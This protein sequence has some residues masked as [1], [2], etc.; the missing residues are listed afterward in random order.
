[1]PAI[2]PNN[3]VHAS[4]SI[5]ILKQIPVTSKGNEGWKIVKKLVGLKDTGSSMFCRPIVLWGRPKSGGADAVLYDRKGIDYRHHRFPLFSRRNRIRSNGRQSFLHS[6]SSH[7]LISYTLCTVLSV[8]IRKVRW[9]RIQQIDRARSPRRRSRQAT[10]ANSRF[11]LHREDF[12]RASYPLPTFRVRLSISVSLKV[13]VL[14]LWYS[15]SDYNQLH[16]DPAIGKAIG[17]GGV[18]SHGLIAYGFAAR[19][20]C[21]TV[22]KGDATRLTY[23]SARFTSPVLPGQTMETKMWVSKEGDKI[24]VD[25]IES[26]KETGKVCLGGGVALLR[27]EGASKL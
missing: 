17:F 18:I 25:F 20:L 10:Y 15:L 23:M 12:R 16:I 7:L 14:R 8:R 22:G 26:V 19:A 4:Q 24:R 9:K 11:R 5:E 2:N 27:D 3:F 6:Y 1:M 21:A 13:R